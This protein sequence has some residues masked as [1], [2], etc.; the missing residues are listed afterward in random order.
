MFPVQT[1]STLA[2][3]R[4]FTDLSAPSGYAIAY[5]RLSLGGSILRSD[6]SFGGEPVITVPNHL[7]E[8]AG[9]VAQLFFRLSLIVEGEFGLIAEQC[10]QRRSKYG[11]FLVIEDAK[12]DKYASILK[13][14]VG[15]AWTR[16]GAPTRLAIF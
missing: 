2:G 11:F 13:N 7:I 8:G 10:D 1:N 9:F 16:E 15:M 6:S 12:I 14:Q 5:A 3:V 4:L